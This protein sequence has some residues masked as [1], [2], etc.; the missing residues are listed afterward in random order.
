MME[1]FYVYDTFAK[2]KKKK[3]KKNDFTSALHIRRLGYEKD[4]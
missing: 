1:E 2:K 4:G 3:K